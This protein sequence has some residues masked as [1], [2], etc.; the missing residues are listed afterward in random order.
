[1]ASL[2]KKKQ[3]GLWC[4]TYRENGKQRVRS[5]RTKNKREALKLKREIETILEDEGELVLNVSDKPKSE[6][7]NPR[8]DE[9]W[10]QFKDWAS[11]N[12]SRS[13]AEEYRNW[14]KQLTEFT[15]AEH[16]GDITPAKIE[17]FKTARAIQGKN[18]RKGVGLKKQ[19]INDGL[20]TLN[21]IWNHAIKLGLY[22][23]E[24][25][26][27]NI[28]RY[29]LPIISDKDYLESEQ[30]DELLRTALEYRDVK[31]VRET[32][33]RNVYLATALMALVG[34]RKGEA[35][36]AKWEWID[37]KKKVLTVSNDSDFT[38]KNGRPR[39]ISMNA[40][41]I[42]ILRSYCEIEGF[43]LKS[44]R[45]GDNR[46]RYRADFK[47]AFAQIC[48]IAGISAT[49]HSLRHSFASRHAV[50]GTSLHVIAG[51]LGHS[52]TWITQRYAHFQ[53]TYNEAAENI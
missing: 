27:A 7:K 34:L 22:T 1:M 25:P 39:I 42:E 31:F 4:I 44:T 2:W 40:H 10:I 16:M 15:E 45:C 50:A 37:W 20:K 5:L 38:T 24:N 18:T 51:W 14:F 49:P 13:A 33:A 30:I 47:K 29:K 26:V 36:F 11:Q 28:E 17:E 35:C 9:F 46:S 6:H 48:K 53:K 52:T 19:S 41:L 23:G 8:I 43:I 21:S 3:S 32:E 12:R